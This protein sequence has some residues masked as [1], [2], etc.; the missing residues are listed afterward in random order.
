MVINKANL[1]Y[2]TND[3]SLAVKSLADLTLTNILVAPIG[4]S[5]WQIGLAN[6]IWGGSFEGSRNDE[7]IDVRASQA[8]FGVAAYP[9]AEYT[10]N[11]TFNFRTVFGQTAFCHTRA[12]GNLSKLVRNDGYQSIGLGVSLTRDVFLYPNFQFSTENLSTDWLQNRFVK[13]STVGMS[14]TINAF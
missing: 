5:G 3:R 12:M 13:E 7:G 8:D 11:D 14:A 4:K 1:T 2:Y 10:I 9:F 6:Y